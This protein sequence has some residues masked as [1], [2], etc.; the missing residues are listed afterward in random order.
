MPTPCVV[1]TPESVAAPAVRIK[2][3]QHKHKQQS[4]NAA[5][6]LLTFVAIEQVIICT[7][8]KVAV[9]FQNLDT[10][11]RVAHKLHFRPRRT[12]VAQF[13]GLPAAQT[14][15]DLKPRRD[16]SALLSYLAAPTSGYSCLHCP[17]F[18]GISWDHMRQHAK[19]RH[20]ISAPECLRQ[21]FR[22]ACAL[23]SWT[24]YSPKYWTVTELDQPPSMRSD[25]Y[26]GPHV[27]QD[28][29]SSEEEALILMETEEEQRL[30]S[31][32]SHSVALDDEVDHDENTE[33]LKGCEWPT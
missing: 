14:I 25:I 17:V 19:K 1:E 6:N 28:R 10:H 2:S 7:S 8:W 13:D 5:L 4:D 30:L 18:K 9:P 24:K 15:T 23:Q 3:T 26:H 20:L 12:I 22:L 16:G 32:Q 29:L 27:S 11:L 33:W 31:E 21:K